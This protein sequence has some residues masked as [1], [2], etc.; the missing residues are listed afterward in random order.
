MVAS[1]LSAFTG[2][3]PKY[4]VLARQALEGRELSSA[5]RDMHVAHHTSV[6]LIKDNLE[7]IDDSAMQASDY[8]DVHSA[9]NAISLLQDIDRSLQDMVAT[10]IRHSSETRLMQFIEVAID[11]V[12]VL[13][14]TLADAAR[15]QLEAD[16]L[17][18]RKI[19]TDRTEVL[20]RFRESYFP[21]GTDVT[22]REAAGLLSIGDQFDAIVRLA[23]QYEG[24]LS[25]GWSGPRFTG[26]QA[27]SSDGDLAAPEF[28]G[29][30]HDHTR[31]RAG[32]IF[33]AFKSRGADRHARPERNW[34]AL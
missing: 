17:L 30:A 4:M 25:S 15:S 26:Q 10:V 6:G 13:L 9:A 2:Q 19:T 27:W 28:G 31:F 1:D 16:R 23:G 34:G 5:L 8:E 32:I 29:A 33:F 22:G 18:L 7:E 3:L 21:Q 11:A 24:L 12:D 20:R 14:L